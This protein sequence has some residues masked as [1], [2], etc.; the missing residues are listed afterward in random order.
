[1]VV[2]T[3]VTC[4]TD[5]LSGATLASITRL[6]EA[7]FQESFEHYWEDIGPAVHFMALSGDDLL[8]H[9]CVVERELHTQ[10]HELHTGYVE[11]VASRPESQGRGHG[12]TV[13]RAVNEFIGD[14]YE[15]GG[16]STGSKGFYERLGWETWRGPTSI[17]LGDGRVARTPEEDGSV[18]VLRTKATPP[19]DI[20]SPLSAEWRPGELW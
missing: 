3:V 5:K 19:L 14:R 2:V 8:A 20:A 15:L 17:R 9:A 16:L 11:A 13:M 18:M 4:P 10:G 1:M 6:C 7:A 12:S